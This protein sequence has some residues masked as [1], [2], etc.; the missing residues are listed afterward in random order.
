MPAD[1]IKAIV[2]D[3]GGVFVQTKDKNPRG[4]LAQRLGLSYDELSEVVFQSETARR[5]TVGA[6]D[7]SD[8]WEFIASHFNLNDHQL[9]RFRDDFWRGDYLDQDLHEY[10]R[11]LKKSI[12]SVCYPMPGMALGID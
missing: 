12:H 4:Q 1:I 9:E 6:V 2:F 7:E 8:H 3:M 11:G 10:A 5:A